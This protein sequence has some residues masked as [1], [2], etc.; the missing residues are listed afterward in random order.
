MAHWE[1]TVCCS[2][3]MIVRE[4]YLLDSP[5]V[6]E[7][8][9]GTCVTVAEEDWSDN[10]KRFRIVEPCKGWCSGKFVQRVACSEDKVA[11]QR[12]QT[13]LTSL[14]PGGGYYSASL[15]NT[16]LSAKTSMGQKFDLPAR[17]EAQ[18]PYTA[19]SPST[20]A[21]KK[22]VQ[23][24]AAGADVEVNDALWQLLSSFSPVQKQAWA[25]LS[26]SSNE[27]AAK[28][29][30]LQRLTALLTEDQ[31]FLLHKVTI[32]QESAQ[33]AKNC[34]LDPRQFT[35][36]HFWL[37]DCGFGSEVNN[38]ISAA[39]MCQEYGIPCVVE[40]DK[41]NSGHLHDYLSAAPWIHMIC[42]LN[43]KCVHRLEVKRNRRTATPGWFAVCKHARGISLQQK[44]VFTQQLWR[45]TA[46]TGQRVTVLN[47]ELQLQ[48]CYVAVQI[49]RG[50]KI[51]GAAKES[52]AVS[53]ADYAKAAL[54][55][56]VPSG[57]CT[58]VIVCTDDVTAAEE[59]G[60]MLQHSH[61]GLPVRWRRRPDAPEKLRQGHWQAEFNSQ[62]LKER[63][64]L[65]N[66]FLADMEVMKNAHTLICTFSS[67]VGR[68]A[69]LLR[70]GRCT[71]RGQTV[72][73][74]SKWTNT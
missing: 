20:S 46:S 40:D 4:A 60:I 19:L 13:D 51:K 47:R 66:V 8:R 32:T 9:P 63:I 64:D 52:L 41:W 55:R 7:L 37:G 44:A 53:I 59:L 14:K 73:L 57:P 15:K 48:F 61:P 69:A 67:N 58:A 34:D 26:A 22:P 74:D 38:L 6:C 5:I 65:T 50:D 27:G 56:C 10:R 72:S 23:T 29:Q 45:L 68:M 3:A 31:K 2:N 36:L 49:R 43:E 11:Q 1:G 25:E 70:E 42:P 39:V 24:A 17:D 18:L 16:I 62:P 21:I 30:R 12:R 33:A 54:A 35:C 71:V 28:Q